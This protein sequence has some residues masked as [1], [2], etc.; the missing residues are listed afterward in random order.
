M[1]RGCGLIV[2]ICGR[3]GKHLLEAEFGE[4]LGSFAIVL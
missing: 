4:T 3:E 2:V 1:I